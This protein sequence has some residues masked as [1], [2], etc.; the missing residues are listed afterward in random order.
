MPLTSVHFYSLISVCQLKYLHGIALLV[1][2]R[3]NNIRLLLSMIYHKRCFISQ[4]SLMNSF[5]KHQNRQSLH[6]RDGT[7]ESSAGLSYT[8]IF[9]QHSSLSPISGECLTLQ[10]SCRSSSMR[11]QKRENANWFK[12][13]CYIMLYIA[14]PAP[15]DKH[16]SSTI[17]S[18]SMVWLYNFREHVVSSQLGKVQVSTPDL[19]S[20]ES[21][22]AVLISH[23]CY[24]RNYDAS[25]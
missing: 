1:V 23:C 19:L 18:R 3:N 25:S 24:Q 13:K 2:H 16:N 20:N 17:C 21:S 10:L 6:S 7:D 14:T 15:S 22:G 8:Y 9:S 12:Q 5:F 11:L 4:D